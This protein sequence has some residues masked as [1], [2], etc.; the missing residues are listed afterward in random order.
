MQLTK[1]KLGLSPFDQA[2]GG[3]Y[4]NKPVLIRGRKKSGKSILSTHFICKN[5]KAGERVILFTDKRPED[6]FLDANSMNFDFA[7]AVEAEQLMLISYRNMHE[8]GGAFD[9]YAPLPLPEA[10]EELKETVKRLNI[11]YVVFDTAVPW[12]AVPSVKD[13]PAHVDEFV[14]T[15]NRLGLTSIFLLPHAASEAAKSLDETLSDL[16]PI[17]IDLQTRENNEHIIRVVKYQGNNKTQVPV[18]FSV[19]LRPGKGFTSSEP[20][21]E[22]ETG[23][24]A[25][26]KSLPQKRTLKPL[27]ATDFTGTPKTQRMPAAQPPVPA[28]PAATSQTP[29]RKHGGFRSV[30]NTANAFGSASRPEQPSQ[31][32]PHSAGTPAGAG[33]PALSVPPPVLEQPAKTEKAPEAKSFEVPEAA[34]P[35]VEVPKSTGKKIS[36]SNV[37]KPFGEAPVGKRASQQGNDASGEIK[38][39]DIFKRQ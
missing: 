32:L 15:L 14:S 34:Q 1:T 29:M 2:F 21:A 4:F 13:M 36:F 27:V 24:V 25:P 9:P 39:S 35:K 37:I 16:C 5:I 11:A 22:L 20:S 6:V 17:V 23:F 10:L 30:I 31:V 26:S 38:F 18:D 28:A 7:P 8:V 33:Q 3:I 12:L 19:E